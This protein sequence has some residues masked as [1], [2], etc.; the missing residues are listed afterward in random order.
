MPETNWI[1]QMLLK[2]IGYEGSD[3][4]DF[5]S[6]LKFSQ[7]DVLVD[8]RDVPSSRKK[9]FSKNSLREGVASVGI[10]YIHMKALGDPKAGRTAARA[11]EM[12][13]FRKIF[14]EHISTTEANE[15][16]KVLA[17]LAREKNVCL[18]CFERDHKACHRSIVVEK[19]LT[20]GDFSIKHIGVPNGFSQK[21]A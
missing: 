17:N 7:V 15:S 20:L 13:K 10:E 8:I 18:L 16:L 14:C 11:G 19:L 21:A 5:I 9:G 6:V 3:I 1:R 12:V 4:A 2:T